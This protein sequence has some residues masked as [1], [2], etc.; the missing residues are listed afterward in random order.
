[1]KPISIDYEAIGLSD[2]QMGDFLMAMTPETATSQVMEMLQKIKDGNDH[3]AHG[4]AVALVNLLGCISSN[5]GA[6]ILRQF[7]EDEIN[8]SAPQI[9]TTAIPEVPDFVDELRIPDE[10][11][12]RSPASDDDD[13]FETLSP[14]ETSV[15]DHFHDEVMNDYFFDTIFCRLQSTVNFRARHCLVDVL[16]QAAIALNPYDPLL[17]AERIGMEME[18]ENSP[19]LFDHME[20]VRNRYEGIAEALA[21]YDA[22]EADENSD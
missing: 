16:N 22:E 21:E 17:Q 18:R 15:I 7:N 13:T 6:A 20:S 8:K 5:I 12:I 14:V 10:F 9:E 19:T 1:M 3:K 4:A 11:L 2:I